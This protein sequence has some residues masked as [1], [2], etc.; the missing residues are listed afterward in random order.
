MREVAS[1]AVFDADGRMLWGRRRDNDRWTL[2]GGHLNS[3]EMP[4]A[5][6]MRELWEEAGL[7]VSVDAVETLGDHEVISRHGP[8]LVH[9]FQTTLDDQHQPPTST[10]NDPDSE[11]AQWKW[12]DVLEGL[13]ADVAD[14]P[15]SPQNVVL[16]FLGMQSDDEVHVDVPD[17]DLWAHEM[18]EEG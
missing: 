14:N 15:H 9:A 10:A 13:P 16:T 17:A 7:R 1:I 8:I 12:M 11:I 5:A 18:R 6:A 2:P 4:L 3:G